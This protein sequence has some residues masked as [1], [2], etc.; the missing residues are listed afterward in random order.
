MGKKEPGTSNLHTAIVFNKKKRSKESFNMLKRELSKAVV[1]VCCKSG[2]ANSPVYTTTTTEKRLIVVYSSKELVS[3]NYKKYPLKEEPFSE[4]AAYV[5]NTSPKDCQGIYLNLGTNLSFYLSR[6]F[7]ASTLHQHNS[8]EKIT[9]TEKWLDYKTAYKS[10]PAKKQK[11]F[12]AGIPDDFDA[13]FSKIS[14]DI[15]DINNEIAIWYL[16]KAL[17]DFT[18]YPKDKF[19]SELKLMQLIVIPVSLKLLTTANFV[20][21]IVLPAALRNHIPVIPIIL[22]DNLEKAF[23]DKFGNMQYLYDDPNDRTAIPYSEKLKAHIESLLISG[24]LSERI[25]KE[26]ASYMFLSYRKAD[27]EYAQKIM[28]QLPIFKRP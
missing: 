2:S 8:I 19:I 26:F 17:Q 20:M 28:K 10:S 24:E 18:T 3:D 4:I 5:L 27:R 9:N 6:E 14:H 12:F 21:D 22:S 1:F 25:R 13:S 11:V 23:Y 16:P 7:I 15:F